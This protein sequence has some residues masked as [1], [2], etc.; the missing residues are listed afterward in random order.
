MPLKLGDSLGYDGIRVRQESRIHLAGESLGV[1]GV[2]STT[3]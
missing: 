3:M 2:T 1:E